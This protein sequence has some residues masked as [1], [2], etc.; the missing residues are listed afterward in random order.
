MKNDFTYN[1]YFNNS[2][3]TFQNAME[4]VLINYIKELINGNNCIKVNI[5][6]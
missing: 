3:E 2:G 6:V 1:V 5:E 4:N